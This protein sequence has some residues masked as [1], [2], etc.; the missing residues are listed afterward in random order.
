MKLSTSDSPELPPALRGAE[1]GSWAYHS[2]A[3]RLP[4]IARRT[5]SENDFPPHVRAAFEELIAE[6]PAGPIRP[7]RDP[8]APDEAAWGGYVEPHLGADWLQP[9]WLFIE[10]Y[11]YRRIIEAVGHYQLDPATRIDP[12]HL[13]KSQGLAGAEVLVEQA[14]DRKSLPKRLLTALWSNQLDLS[15]WPKGGSG[16]G[17]PA[18]AM[19][20]LLVDERGSIDEHLAQLEG[21]SSRVDLVLDNAGHELVADL[22]LAEALLNGRR[23]RSVILHLKP[24]PTYVSDAT[25][26]D[27]NETLV[28]LADSGSGAARALA[29][30]L[31]RARRSSR[32]RLRSDSF[33]TSPLPGWRLPVALTQELTKSDL[34]I[35]KGDYNYR[36]LLGDR[37]WHPTRPF[38]EIVSY[39]PAPAA[40]LRTLKADLVVGLLRDQMEQAADR[41]PK[42]MINGRWGLIQFTGRAASGQPVEQ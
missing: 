20:R 33:W 30:R 38:P 21:N 7:I 12:F 28:Y 9:P 6:I 32:L 39:L 2:I 16:Q 18:P 23:G 26:R 24:H 19:D 4:E 36:R 13:Q 8:Q 25:P 31:D 17:A 11:F 22:L 1:S 35:F 29:S 3:T 40:A 27:L 15:L 14:Q 37:R 34:L 10:S 42:W 5:L 41:D